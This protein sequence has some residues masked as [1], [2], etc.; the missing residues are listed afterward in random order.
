MISMLARP[1]SKKVK[2]MVCVRY[3]ILSQFFCSIGN[4]ESD[5]YFV[6]IY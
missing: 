1:N 2:R 4:V 3:V 5:G 6:K